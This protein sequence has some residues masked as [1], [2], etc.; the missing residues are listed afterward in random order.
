MPTRTFTVSAGRA[1][2][3]SRNAGTIPGIA[4]GRR[5]PPQQ[6]PTIDRH[7]RHDSD[8]TATDAVSTQGNPGDDGDDGDNGDFGDGHPG[9]P[10]DEP[11]DDDGPE[12]N[13]HDDDDSDEEHHN[14]ADAIAALAKNV[15]NQGDGSRSKVREPDP[16]DGTDP[17]KLRTFLVQLQ[18]SFNDRPRAFQSDRR[19]VNFAISYLKGMALAHFENSLIEPDPFNPPDWEDDYGEFVSELKMYFGSPDI[20]GEAENKLENLTMKPT[21]RIAKYH[22]EFNRLATITG[23]DERALRHQFYRGL[24]ARIKDEV[25]RVGKPATLPALRILA[26][27]I[28]GRYWEREEETRRER[29]GQSSEKKTEKPQHQAASSS[30][31]TS[32][33]RSNKGKQKPFTPRDSGSSSQNSERRTSDLGDKI[34]KDG[35]LTAAER[36]RRFANNLCLF[37]GGVGH[38]AKECPKSSSASSKAKAR[39]S[40]ARPESKPDSPPTE[41]AKK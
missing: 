12:G 20:V 28:D 16:F 6:T 8:K 13:P 19:K 26:L 37:C 33:N 23:W 32:H 29:G 38:T 1:T 30:S 2:R 15:K 17:T 36:S 31:S 35:K 34:G 7:E 5:L 9:N 22:V 14:L 11:P 40:K 25:S 21:Q 4:F 41:D 39:S 3:N 24:P 18:L 27:Q 10:G